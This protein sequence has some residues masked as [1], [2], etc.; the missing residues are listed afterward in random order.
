NKINIKVPYAY[1]FDADII[2]TFEFAN[3]VTW[4]KGNNDSDKLYS[5]Y[6]VLNKLNGW[7]NAA[8]TGVLWDNVGTIQLSTQR[9]DDTWAKINVTITGVAKNAEGDLKTIQI[10]DSA[11]NK[12]N[13]TEAQVGTFEV[14][15]PKD[16]KI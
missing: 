8:A 3:D 9:A 10:T 5:N 14:E 4:V 1:D 11:D 6:T 16:T 7:N 13:T 2:P 12:S 15:M